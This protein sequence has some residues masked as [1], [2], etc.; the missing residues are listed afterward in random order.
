MMEN[1][2]Q[3][4]PTPNMEQVP[5]INPNMNNSIPNI[6]MQPNQNFSNQMNNQNGMPFTGNQNIPNNDNW[7]L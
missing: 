4:M 6:N 1:V 3:E 2:N 5:N 7:R